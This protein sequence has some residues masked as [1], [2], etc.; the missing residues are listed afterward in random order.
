MTNQPDQMHGNP[1]IDM[2]V[3]FIL[4]SFIVTLSFLALLKSRI[5]LVLYRRR[6]HQGISVTEGHIE[7]LSRLQ[8]C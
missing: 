8:W 5:F 7:N 2:V 4:S 6:H 3:S 1:I